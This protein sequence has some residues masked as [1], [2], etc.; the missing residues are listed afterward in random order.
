MKPHL[1]TRSEIWALLHGLL[2]SVL[3]I[4]AQSAWVASHGW[5]MRNT[6][7][8][9]I[10]HP[11]VLI[12]GAA[13]VVISILILRAFVR[14]PTGRWVAFVFCVVGFTVMSEFLM[15]KIAE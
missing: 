15:P 4:M 13:V 8:Y 14:R 3:V 12:G 2:V 5:S 9:S 7:L 6:L 10:V 1:D 11:L